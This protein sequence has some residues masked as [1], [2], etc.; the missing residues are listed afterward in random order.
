VR[1]SL[2]H[3]GDGSDTLTV[4]VP[5]GERTAIMVPVDALPAFLPLLDEAIEELPEQCCERC[6]ERLPGLRTANEHAGKPH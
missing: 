5:G 3:I 2:I 6:G 4:V 1:F